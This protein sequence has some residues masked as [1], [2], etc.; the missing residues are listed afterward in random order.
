MKQIYNNIKEYRKRRGWTQD[1]LAR[2]VGY[3][4]RGMISQIEKGKV[5]LPL[6]KVEKFAEV[7]GVR[8]SVLMGWKEES[9]A[10]KNGDIIEKYKALDR[11]DREVVDWLLSR[12]KV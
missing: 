1:D 6:S 2:K 5:D 12:E 8:P 7:F 4:D 11:K 3:S 10:E 9:P